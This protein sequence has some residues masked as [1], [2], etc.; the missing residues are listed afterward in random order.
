MYNGPTLVPQQWVEVDCGF[1]KDSR[2]DTSFYNSQK[3]MEATI[4]WRLQA[5]NYMDGEEPVETSILIHKQK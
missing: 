3:G 4:P 1:L 2:G 5:W